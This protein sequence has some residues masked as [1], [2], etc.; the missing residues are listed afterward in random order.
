MKFDDGVLTLHQSDINNYRKCPEQFRLMNLV[1][2][3]DP[4]HAERSESDA[5]LVGTIGH[6]MIERDLERP[7]STKAYAIKR[8]KENYRAAVAGFV[9]AGVNF[10]T[11]TFGSEAKAL[12]NVEAIVR[13]W[14]DSDERDYWLTAVNDHGDLILVERTFDVPFLSETSHPD[15]KSVRLSGTPDIVDRYRNV[16]VDWKFPGRKYQRWEQQRWGVQESA[17]TFAMASEGLILPNEDGL[18]EFR[19]KVFIRNE[20]GEPQTVTVYRSPSQWAWLA[21]MVA[22]IVEQMSNTEH[23]WPLR[24]DHAL[25]GPKWCPAWSG[26]KGKWVEVDWT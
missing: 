23:R 20:Q 14:W 12:A 4:D 26:C 7:Y 13:R 11:E 22:N 25:C 5:A 10:T 18:Y 16:I 19:F 8:A 17:Y 1:P 24:D 9:E 6:D 2:D 15:I 21:E 3:D